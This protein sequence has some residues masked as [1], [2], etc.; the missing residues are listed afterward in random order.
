MI[1]PPL[2]PVTETVCMRGRVVFC[3]GR[4]RRASD[5]AEL[6][7][8]LRASA[9][10]SSVVQSCLGDL[11]QSVACWSGTD[12]CGRTWT[13]CLLERGSV[14][15]NLWPWQEPEGEP[16]LRRTSLYV[17]TEAQLLGATLEDI[18]L[19]LADKLRGY[20]LELDGAWGKATVPG[21]AM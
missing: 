21:E 2:A 14:L 8:T 11:G 18:K 19:T 3:P 4:G 9:I 15:F 7:D 12:T 6:S 20:G 5:A 10:V 1:P 17:N 13:I 16:R